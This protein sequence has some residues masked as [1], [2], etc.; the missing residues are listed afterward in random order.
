MFDGIVDSSRL[1][2]QVNRTL[3]FLQKVSKEN[4]S[5]ISKDDKRLRNYLVS[6][7]KLNREY[8]GTQ[9]FIRKYPVDDSEF[10]AFKRMF[11]N[12][13]KRYYENQTDEFKKVKKE[14]DEKL[15]YDFYVNSLKNSLSLILPPIFIFSSFFYLSRLLAPHALS[16]Y[17]EGNFDPLEF[18]NDQLPLIQEFCFLSDMTEQANTGVDELIKFHT[19]EGH[20]VASV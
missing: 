11:L 14:I 4:I 8:K 3:R 17:P 18:Y 12:M 10:R 2:N 1:S 6:L 9:E 13:V 5:T 16:R 15:T 7:K 19:Q 20:H